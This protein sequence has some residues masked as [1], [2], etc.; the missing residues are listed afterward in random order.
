M[1]R[2]HVIDEPFRPGPHRPKRR[3]EAKTG[4][5]N[6]TRDSFVRLVPDLVIEALNQMTCSYPHISALYAIATR[7]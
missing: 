2:A 4:V 3:L 7:I 6:L 5:Q 1:N